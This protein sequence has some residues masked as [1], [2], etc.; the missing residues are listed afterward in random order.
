LADPNGGTIGV[1]LNP[2]LRSLNRN[3]DRH[4]SQA[5][6][7][8]LSARMGERAFEVAFSPD[9]AS[10]RCAFAKLPTSRKKSVKTRLKSH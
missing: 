10:R 5:S 7:N 9:E 1:K 6:Q 4:Q 8:Q 2:A 3:P